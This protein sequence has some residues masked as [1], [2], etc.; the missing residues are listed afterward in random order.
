VFIFNNCYINQTNLYCCC[1][2]FD[3]TNLYNLYC[4][5]IILDVTLK[6]ILHYCI[7]LTSLPSSWLTLNFKQP[8]KNL[9]CLLKIVKNH[10]FPPSKEIHLHVN[11]TGMDPAWSGMVGVLCQ[12]W[13]WV[14]SVMCAARPSTYCI[15]IVVHSSLIIVLL[16]KLLYLILSLLFSAL[17]WKKTPLARVRGV[18]TPTSQ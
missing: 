1:I 4:C 8:F 13:C 15:W 11:N 6:I 12:L 10:V 16:L 18:H 17:S 5:C 9:D 14:V 2:I 7:V 3:V